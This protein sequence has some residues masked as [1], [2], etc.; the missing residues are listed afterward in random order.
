MCTIRLKSSLSLY[1]LYVK[2]YLLSNVICYNNVL[3]IYSIKI[4]EPHKFTHVLITLKQ[5]LNRQKLYTNKLSCLWKSLF[6]VC[7]A[8]IAYELWVFIYNT[9]ELQ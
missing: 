7:T 3:K 6:R 8:K 1:V 2:S 4:F 5:S 9:V